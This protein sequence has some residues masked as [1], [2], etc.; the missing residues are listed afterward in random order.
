MSWI[1]RFFCT[2]KI[3]S[4]FRDSLICFN[5]EGWRKLLQGQSPDYAWEQYATKAWSW[6]DNTTQKNKVEVQRA[7][8]LL[9]VCA[10]CNKQ[11]NTS[12]KSKDKDK[13]LFC[14]CNG[15]WIHT[16]CCK[17]N[18]RS[19]TYS[20]I[21]DGAGFCPKCTPPVLEVGFS[22]VP[23]FYLFCNRLR[24]ILRKV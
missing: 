12:T 7:A 3:K 22:F 23:K 18:K 8:A 2:I 9:K 5:M 6:P 17:G 13:P 4:R 21:K 24:C 16:G 15:K 14:D 20:Y 10:V 19:S 1:W 11:L